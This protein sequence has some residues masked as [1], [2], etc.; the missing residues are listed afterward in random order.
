MN[1]KR[2]TISLLLLA[3]FMVHAYAQNGV[4]SPVSRYGFGQLSD[5]TIGRSAAMGGASLGL[6]AGQEINLANPASYSA[7]DSLT[8]LVDAGISVENTNYSNGKTR[9]NNKSGSFDYI[10]MQF[11][12]FRKVGMAF[13]FAPFS[14]VGYDFGEKKSAINDIY[15]SVT[16]GTSYTGE[17]GV[18]KAFLGIGW[19]PFAGLSVGVNGE[20]L[21]GNITNTVSNAYS[22]TNV[23]SNVRSYTARISTYNWNL[24]L[25]YE[26][27]IGKVDGLTIGATFNPGHDINNEAYRQDYLFDAQNEKNE[28][29]TTDTIKNAFQMPKS[30]GIGFTYNHAKKLTVLADFTLQKWG[31]CRFPMTVSDGNGSSQFESKAGFLADR[32]KV[33]VG[34]EYVPN[35]MSRS[36]LKRIHYRA[37]AYYATQY[38]RIGKFDPGKEYGLTVGL[39]LPIQNQWNNK[40]VVNISGQYVHVSPSDTQLLVENHFRVCVSLTFD[41][42]WFMKWK[43]Q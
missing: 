27:P 35:L 3:I 17:G 14:K 6:R 1:N 12:A 43:A 39:G 2:Y 36:Y 33:S 20:F 37:G 19:N 7:V 10:A 25:Q 11:R 5:M 16:P 30:Y 42:R 40:S 23:F 28:G 32:K 21:F 13:G 24:G 29:S 41:E 38:A 31:D 4:T 26:L 18:T 22:D 8:F 15:G 34:M 9:L